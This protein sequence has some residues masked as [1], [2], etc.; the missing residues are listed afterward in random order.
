MTLNRK[1]FD[2]VLSLVQKLKA[3]G[4]EDTTLSIHTT[5]VYKKSFT[6]PQIAQNDFAV[7]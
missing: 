2:A 3:T 6:F 1:H 5:D 7:E 4:A